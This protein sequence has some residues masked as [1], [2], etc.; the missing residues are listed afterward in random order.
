MAP[1]DQAASLAWLEQAVKHGNPYAQHDL[2]VMFR[3][4][5]GAPQ[6]SARALELFTRAAERDHTGAQA[7][8]G[9][10]YYKGQGVKQDLLAASMWFAL[11]AEGGDKS[12]QLSRSIIAPSLSEA[13]LARVDELKKRWKAEHL[14]D[15]VPAQAANETGKDAHGASKDAKGKGGGHG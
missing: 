11:A 12:A 10:M 2:A 15:P 6:D 3:D 8:L 5:A 1:R 7:A 14:L 13:Q 9:Q 4:G